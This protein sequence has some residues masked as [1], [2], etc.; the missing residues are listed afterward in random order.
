LSYQWRFNGTNLANGGQFSGSTTA[1]LSVSNVQSTNAG[2]YTVQVTNSAGSVVSAPAVLTVLVPPSITAQPV[3]RTNAVGTTVTFSV[4]ATGTAPLSYQWQLNG[5]AL[6]NG[7]NFSGST[8]ATLT[9]NVQPT[10]V[11]AYRLVVTNVAGAATSAV[12]TLSLSG[13]PAITLQPA[14][15]TNIAG[16]TA[17]F[18]VSATGTSPLSYQWRFNGT[19]IA[20]RGQFSGSATATL[21]VSN[22]QSTNAGSYTVQV[23]NSAGSVVSAPAVLTV[24]VPPSITVQPTSRTSAVGTTVVFIAMATGTAPL[25]YQWQLNGLPLT[26]GGNFHI[27]T[28]ETLTVDVQPTTVGAYRL[29]VTNV[30]GAAT[31]AVATLAIS[32][33]PALVTRTLPDNNVQISLNIATLPDNNAQI[34][35]DAAS[36]LTCCLE[37]STDLVN[38]TTLTNI[39]TQNGINQ[40]ID[41][42]ATNFQWRFYRTVSVPRPLVP[43]KK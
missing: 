13:P 41:L 28:T 24:L 7:G 19:N 12:A 29:V 26:N 30:A 40:F 38:W 42:E 3:S 27:S 22:V 1:S 23:T 37:V 15:V 21:S 31:S 5:L 39:N 20:N 34:S 33:A 11:G 32:P 2:S 8:T 6:T 4:M 36:D 9:V 14:S 43:Q 10:D 25:S 16:T 18:T 35:F 17:V